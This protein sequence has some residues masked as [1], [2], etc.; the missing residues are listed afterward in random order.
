VAGVR[1]LP[2]GGDAVIFGD[3]VAV[4]VYLKLALAVFMA[5][6]TVVTGA[7][8]TASTKLPVPAVVDSVTTIDAVATMGLA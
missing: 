5:I 2:P 8:V 1:V 6:V 3:P 7:L 4:S